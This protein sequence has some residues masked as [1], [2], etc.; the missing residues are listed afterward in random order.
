MRRRNAS[1][2][3][4]QKGSSGNIFTSDRLHWTLSIASVYSD[5]KNKLS[6]KRRPACTARLNFKLIGHVLQTLR[7]TIMYREAAEN[8]YIAL[9]ASKK[10]VVYT[11]GC[12][13]NLPNV[14]LP[15]PALHIRFTVHSD[16]SRTSLAPNRSTATVRSD[17][18]SVHARPYRRVQ[19]FL[20]MAFTERILSSNPVPF[21]PREDVSLPD[22]Q[23]CRWFPHPDF[24]HT[25]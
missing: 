4:F 25:L 24:A 17:F 5:Y 16:W 6:G 1:F 12:N 10:M 21:P 8:Y 3:K 2:N 18:Y 19:Y 7:S 11:V 9:W 22:P 14:C 20:K 23:Q 13:G 15:P